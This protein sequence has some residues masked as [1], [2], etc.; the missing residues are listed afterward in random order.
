M[1]K[2]ILFQKLEIP[3]D[4]IQKSAALEKEHTYL[5][6]EGRVKAEEQAQRMDD[7]T[8]QAWQ[9][10]EFHRVCDNSE[11]FLECNESFLMTKRKKKGILQGHFGGD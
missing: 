2:D 5:S 1:K 10:R 8:F 7:E 4:V 6:G 3:E 11:A 9:H